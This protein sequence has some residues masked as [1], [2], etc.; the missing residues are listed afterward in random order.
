MAI[1]GW[2]R[3]PSK[4]TPVPELGME[5]A[6]FTWIALAQDNDRWLRAAV[7]EWILMDPEQGQEFLRR[8]CSDPEFRKIFLSHYTTIQPRCPGWEPRRLPP[9]RSYWREL[10]A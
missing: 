10:S 2:A 7:L 1:R 5:V 9:L 4:A 8:A 6:G 3:L